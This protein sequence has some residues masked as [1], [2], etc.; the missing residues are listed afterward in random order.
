MDNDID[1]NELD[2]QTKR[3]LDK[4]CAGIDVPSD[5]EA[6]EAVEAQHGDQPNWD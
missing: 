4:V 5:E 1:I 2:A 3:L 6:D